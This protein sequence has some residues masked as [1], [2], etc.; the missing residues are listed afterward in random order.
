VD[1]RETSG[2][3]QDRRVAIRSVACYTEGRVIL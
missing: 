3:R 2:Q 1:T